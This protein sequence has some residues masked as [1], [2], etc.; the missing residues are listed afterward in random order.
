M[1]VCSIHL[2][3]LRRPCRA[4]CLLN[5]VLAGWLAAL[6]GTFF[7]KRKNVRG[8]WCLAQGMHAPRTLVT[9]AT[10]THKDP[11]VRRP[12]AMTSPTTT[13]LSLAAAHTRPCRT[14]GSLLEPRYCDPVLVVVSD[15]FFFFHFLLFPA[16]GS[17]L[18]HFARP[19]LCSIPTRFFVAFRVIAP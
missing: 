13:Q 17:E 4:D 14:S 7:F 15:S 11:R 9:N 2:Y 5:G 12:S 19:L 16:S 8:Y 10:P 1:S 6:Y 18:T 3:R